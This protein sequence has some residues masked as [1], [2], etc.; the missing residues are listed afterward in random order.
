MKETDKKSTALGRELAEATAVRL[1]ADAAQGQRVVSAHREAGDMEWMVATASAAGQLAN[2]ALLFLTCGVDG[3]GMFMLAGPPDTVKAL[4]PKVAEV[5][6]GRG[7]GKGR[8]QGKVAS[9]SKH[10]EA[11]EMLKGAI[12]S[13]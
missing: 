1:S 7:G 9:V 11:L 8:F 2:D 6:E 13:T 5:L 12:D 3:S 4:G 10:P